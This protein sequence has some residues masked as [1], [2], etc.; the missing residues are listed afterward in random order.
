[1][2]IDCVGDSLLGKG[3]AASIRQDAGGSTS[4]QVAVAGR[5]SRRAA[6]TGLQSHRRRLHYQHVGKGSA[7]I[8]SVGRRRL[9]EMKAA[10]RSRRIEGGSSITSGSPVWRTRHRWGEQW[11]ARPRLSPLPQVRINS[12]VS[13]PASENASRLRC[14]GKCVQTTTW[15][16]LLLRI[17]VNA[18]H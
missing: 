1:M 7:S 17:T 12:T 15:F 3:I 13:S 11:W 2:P 5:P 18:Y 14:V 9:F 4:R 8:T 16:V 6:K 10:L